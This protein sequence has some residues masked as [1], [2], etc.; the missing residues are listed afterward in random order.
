MGIPQ[1]TTVWPD[2]SQRSG[3]IAQRAFTPDEVADFSNPEGKT[4][5]YIFGQV[6]YQDIF[7]KP[8]QTNM[9]LFMD[10]YNGVPNGGGRWVWGHYP[11]RNDFT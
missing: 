7:D 10:G 3:V 4:R 9:C 1:P 6:T 2:K 11:G 5:L 8:R